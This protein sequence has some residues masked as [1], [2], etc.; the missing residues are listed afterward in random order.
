M[1]ST[2]EPLGLPAVLALAVIGCGSPPAPV[3]EYPPLQPLP[4]VSDEVSSAAAPPPA[5]TADATDAHAAHAQP[6]L[7]T[8]EGLAKGAVLLPDLGAH[9]RAVTTA[10]KEAQAFFDQGLAL[11]YGFNHDEAARSFARA[12]QIDPTCAMCFWGAALTLGPNYN[13]PM[14]PERA[15]AAWDAVTR[16]QAAAPSAAPVEQ[17]LIAALAKRYKGPEYVD[18]AAMAPFNQAYADAMRDVARS[19]LDDLDVQ[20]LSAEAQMDLNPWQLWK[21]DGQAA[22]G[23]LAIVKALEA[24][25]QKAPT[26]P[27][28]NHYYIH[29]VEASKTPARAIAAAER[30]PSLIPGAGHIVHMPAHI[31]QRVGR[32]SDASNANQ[33]A[34][35]VDEKYLSA[36]T[37]PGYYRFYLGHN[38]GFLAYSASMEGRSQVALQAARMAA[39]TIPRD[40][41]CGMPGMDFFL[42]E[43]LLVMVRFGRFE[44]LLHEPRPDAKYAVLT[45]LWHHGQGMALA[46]TGK[47]DEARA[48]VEAI[49]AVAAALPPDLVA[50]LNTGKAVLELSAKVVEARI[51]DSQKSAGAIALWQ[52]AVAL[53][54]QLAYS[55]PADWFYPV[56]HYL[57]A[58]LLDAGKAKEAEAVY[59]ADLERNPKNGWALYGVWQA[60]LAQNRAKDAK[61]AEARFRS[62]FANAD[63]S[64]T[65]TAF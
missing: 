36:V 12:A 47:A 24:V 53:E 63:F 45:G 60:L 46:A 4:A 64:L 54:D 22:P 55:E 13:I 62:A 15:V 21:A 65:R 35:E 48:H 7:W 33:R 56:R 40:L 28:A 1:R 43:P 17:A 29:A 6:P 18:P 27:G 51:A 41:V 49:R 38:H 26:H 8:L 5:H 11:T 20:V 57:G 32:Y 37:P 3:P 50:G 39:K 16:A 31:F 61:A 44:E 25:L 10:A 2:I 52:A 19:F 14:L 9:R 23:T 34:I 58:A 42:S 59:R 30:L